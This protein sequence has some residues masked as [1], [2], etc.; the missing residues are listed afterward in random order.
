M[1]FALHYTNRITSVLAGAVTPSGRDVVQSRNVESADIYGVEAAAHFVLSAT[2]TADLVVN[3]VRGEQLEA[4]G[5]EVSA[6]RIPPLNGRLT[7]R[8]AVSDS[9][10]VEPYLLFA[11]SQGRLSPRDIR[12][13]RI[14]PAG[15]PGWVTANV[16]LA[17]QP[18][19]HWQV[20]T[21]LEN[22]FDKQYRVHGSG[23]D[24]TGT[25]LYLSLRTL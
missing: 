10:F 14:N 4:D 15:T 8:Y 24:S 3:Y 23:I 7:L 9:L 11:A 12:D 17:W 20:V 2:T 13:V 1:L 5:V 22:I 6:D 19:E 18:N 16:A 25:N 21:R